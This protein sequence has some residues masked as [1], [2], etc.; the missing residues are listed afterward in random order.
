VGSILARQD[1]MREKCGTGLAVA[2][3]WAAAGH[4]ARALR[5]AP[6]G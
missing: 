2:T 1:W 4:V 6:A 3:A 5:P